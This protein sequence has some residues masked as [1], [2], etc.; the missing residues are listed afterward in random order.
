[1]IKMFL[2][3]VA[4][5]ATSVMVPN[6]EAAAAAVSVPA[7]VVADDYSVMVSITTAEFNTPQEAAAACGPQWSAAANAVINA[8]PWPY[9]AIVVDPQMQTPFIGHQRQVYDPPTDTWKTLYSITANGGVTFH[10]PF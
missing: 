10:S 6:A 8:Q 9:Y 3:M 7:P 1:M 4:L 5:V 2:M